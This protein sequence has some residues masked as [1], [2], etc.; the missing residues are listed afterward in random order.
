MLSLSHWRKVGPGSDLGFVCRQRSRTNWLKWIRRGG[1]WAYELL[2]VAG[3]VCFG[4]AAVAAQTTPRAGNES[5]PLVSGKYEVDPDG[6]FVFQRSRQLV[7]LL[8]AAD[9]Y[10]ARG[11]TVGA[12]SGITCSIPS[13]FEEPQYVVDMPGRTT[14]VAGKRTKRLMLHHTDRR[15]NGGEAR[16]APSML[17]AKVRGSIG[18]ITLSTAVPSSG[19]A[20]WRVVWQ[21][22]E[23]IYEV[24][25]D[26]SLSSTGR[27]NRDGG[28]VL[29]LAESIICVRKPNTK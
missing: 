25:V 15:V 22:D 27:A 4:I 16:F 13:E 19:R 2:R 21:D 7:E 24:Y 28:T 20:L 9:G 10:L 1:C 8:D 6:H 12:P 5:S 14:V 17:N 11:L 26:D 3:F 18:I 23:S 29:R